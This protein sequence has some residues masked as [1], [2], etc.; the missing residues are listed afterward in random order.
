MTTLITG[1]GLIA[2]HVASALVARGEDVVFYD[3]APSRDYLSTV[4]GIDRSTIYT[5]DITNL[6]ELASLAQKHRVRCIVH[7]AALIGA[8]VA[9]QPYHSVQ[10]NVGGTVA[11][12]EAARLAAVRRIIFCSSMAVYDFE[13]LTSH[14]SITEGAPL[15]PKNLYGATKLASELLLDQYGKLYEIEICHLRLA[16]VFGRGH[17]SGGSWMGRILNRILEGAI[18]GE[19]IKIK[20]EWIGTN[21]YVY[22]RDVAEAFAQA[23]LSREPSVGAYNIGTGVIHDF[24]Q[25]VSALR[26]VIPELGLEIQ[27]PDAP[28]VSYLVRNQP[29][30]ISRARAELG[31]VPRYSFETGL[32]DY[33]QELKEYMGH[34]AR[35]I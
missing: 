35:L 26:A 28:T 21:E 25:F 11:V 30:D 15:G 1:A 27:E 16:G 9:R 2:A 10:I 6:P 23:A 31:Y 5:G 29:F 19:T 20:P 33:Y 12:V 22:V 3:L 17:Y 8:N 18:R 14:T 34:Y 4:L 13:R 32:A 7:T 24:A